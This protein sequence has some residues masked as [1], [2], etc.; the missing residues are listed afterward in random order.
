MHFARINIGREPGSRFRPSL[1]RAI[2]DGV[3][4]RVVVDVQVTGF[5][6]AD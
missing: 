2:G 6:A 1:P 3:R 5:G 4:H